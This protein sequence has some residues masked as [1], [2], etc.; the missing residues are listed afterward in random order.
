M[1]N[2]VAIIGRPNVG[3]STLFNK[4][5][6]SRSAIVSNFS[7]LTK[8]RNYGLLSIGDSKTFLI[9]TGG[10][11][12]SKKESIENEI[13]EQAW[14]AVDESSL[15][16]FVI[17]GSEELT[18]LDSKILE[19]LRKRNKKF[20]AILNKNDKKNVSNASFDLSQKG[21]KDSISISA[22]H[23]IGL[24]E[25][26]K[27][28]KSNIAENISDTEEGNSPKI[29]IIGRPNAGKSTLINSLSLKDRVIV[30][31]LAGTTIDAINVPIE[32]GERKYEL[33][34]TAGI[35]KG[36]KTK[37]NI[38]YFS[39]VRAMHAA[40]ESDIT[41]LLIDADSGLVDQDLKILSM[42]E[43]FGKPIILA[44]N[45][46]DLL[47]R[48]KMKE[49]F[50][51]KKM[52]KRFFE[53]LKLVKISALKGKGF[54]KLFKEID[55][56]LQKSVTKFTTSKL[57]RILKRVIE[58]RSPPSVSGK[59]L[60]FRYIHFAGIN[61]TTLV[62]HSSQDK[63]LPA[64]YKKYIYNSFKKYLDLKSIQLKIIFRKSDN[65]YK[66]KN[67]LTERQ[68]KKRKRLLSFVKK[69]KK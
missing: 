29:S 22:E 64:N 43:K 51:N 21:I 54:K 7:G 52:E 25:L 30:S 18:N 20:I 35:R 69:A 26:K 2:T 17:D 39:Y 37:T 42:I 61:P 46:I 55:D 33:F 48:K 10:I 47:S 28:L 56:T 31:P 60:K 50:D 40:S 19:N 16:L 14:I 45:K 66:G 32:F 68:I 6:K 36:Y 8:D 34:D 59:S 62:I 38:E 1:L 3:K 23:S 24:D 49:F 15:V 11:D 58:E 63:K 65:P 5:T 67:T 57:N 9:D 27:Y 53:D 44:I 13:S 41:I 4:L 12:S